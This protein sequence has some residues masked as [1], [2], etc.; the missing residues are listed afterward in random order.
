MARGTVPTSSQHPEPDLR[1]SLRSPVQIP[2]DRN[3]EATRVRVHCVHHGE[4]TPRTV[5]Q[6]RGDA[7]RCL[8][9]HLQSSPPPRGFGYRRTVRTGIR[10]RAK[11][12]T[13][14]HRT[15][16][17]VPHSF[18]PGPTRR[19]RHKRQDQGIRL[20]RGRVSNCKFGRT[21]QHPSPL[22]CEQEL[23]P[24]FRHLVIRRQETET[25]PQTSGSGTS[26]EQHSCGGRV[27]TDRPERPR[28]VTTRPQPVHSGHAAGATLR[29]T[30]DPTPTSRRSRRAPSDSQT[31]S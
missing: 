11:A 24:H 28:A 30:Q 16:R 22:S 31:R 5:V 6:T 27:S 8:R 15:R 1:S 26:Q 14:Q 7:P 18:R 25:S 13:P 20:H 10:T 17:R 12:G 21:H 19:M 23:A 9:S 3:P 2:D 4:P 29:S